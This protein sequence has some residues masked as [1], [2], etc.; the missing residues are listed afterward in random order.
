MVKWA[1]GASTSASWPTVAHALAAAFKLR[2]IVPEV[3]H[4]LGADNEQ[5]SHDMADKAEDA[6]ASHRSRQL[7]LIV[8]QLA[9]TQAPKPA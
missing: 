5:R 1:T 4:A 9:R 3:K 7:Y 8:R 2:T 6:A